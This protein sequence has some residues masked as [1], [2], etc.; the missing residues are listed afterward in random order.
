MSKGAGFSSQKGK[1]HLRLYVADGTPQSILAIRNLKVLCEKHLADRFDLEVIDLLKNP[2]RAQQ[3]QILVVPTLVRKLPSPIRK[4]IGNLSNPERVLV[5][6]NLLP[7]EHDAVEM[8][9]PD[10]E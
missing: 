8:E 3:D 9:T 4:F 2:Q 1:Y 6:F 10:A 5:D 7:S